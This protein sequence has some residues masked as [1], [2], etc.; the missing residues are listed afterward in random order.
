MLEKCGGPTDVMPTR[1][2]LGVADIVVIGTVTSVDGANASL[3]PEAFLKGP[4]SAADLQ[5][6]GPVLI[7][8]YRIALHAG[9][10]VLLTLSSDKGV[11]AWPLAD[12]VGSYLLESGRAVS[13]NTFNNQT[14]DNAPTEAAV[15]DHI[16]S[17]TG[18]YA[19]PATSD[20]Q[21]A[22]LDWVKVVLPV[23]LVTLA[24]FGIG[25][26]L[27]KIWHRIDPT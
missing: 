26:Y 3:K 4:T 10:R 27:M 6:G 20:S 15:V 2:E 17:I 23:A 18:Q 8:C 5:I 19:I 22:S 25:L 7:G 11:L 16:R 9:D 12:G 24:V 14:V 1:Q 21:G 13:L